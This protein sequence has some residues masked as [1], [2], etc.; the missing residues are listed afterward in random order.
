MLYYNLSPKFKIKKKLKRK[1]KGI[2][3]MIK[4]KENKTQVQC[5]QPDA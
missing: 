1:P 2:E 5:S 4:E 3:N